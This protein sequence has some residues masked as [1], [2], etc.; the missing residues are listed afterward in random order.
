[1]KQFKKKKYVLLAENVPV[2]TRVYNY[3]E[4]VDYLTDMGHRVILTGTAKESWV[5]S[6]ASLAKNYTYLNGSAIDPDNLPSVAFNI[7]P[8]T[9]GSVTVFAEQTQ[10]EL[11]ITT[12]R[13]DV[14]H[15]NRPGVSHGG[16]DWIVF[17]NIDGLPNSN[18]RWVVN[19]KVFKDTYEEVG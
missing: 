2:G 11:D 10:E 18:N 4:D 6:A 16:G 1:M 14:L 5:I 9:D 7:V 3:L 17:E 13:G 12:V 15:A 8:I 19:G